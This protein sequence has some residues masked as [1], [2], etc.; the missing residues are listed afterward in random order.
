ME[1]VGAIELGGTKTVCGVVA[2]SGQLL[3]RV[4]FPTTE[5]SET[6]QQAARFL[7]SAALTHG[8]LKGVGVASFGPIC[9][10]QDASDYGRMLRTPK[11][12][13]LDTNVREIVAELTQLPVALDTDVN[14]AL[15]AEAKWGACVGQPSGVYVTV[16]TGIGAGVMIDG[17]VIGGGRHP[18]IGHM[19]LPRFDD[20]KEFA[21]SCPF[22]DGRCAEG[23]ASG[24]AIEQRWGRPAV[25]LDTAH[26]AWDLEARYLAS[27]CLNLMLTLMPTRIILGGGVFRQQQLIGLVRMWFLRF[28]ND[29]VELPSTKGTVDDLIVAPTLG[30]DAGVLGASVVFT[31]RAPT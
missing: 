6:L 7:G 26:P 21:G 5:P 19:M 10:D 29:Y 23:L 11:A 31:E 13:W 2:A 20:D 18:E 24:T 1:L 25:E 22:H 17:S 12:G 14:G 3:E 30:E 28:L 4:S 16:G 9:V 27:L 8:E 15:R